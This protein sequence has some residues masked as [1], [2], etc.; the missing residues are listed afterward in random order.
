MA[1]LLRRNDASGRLGHR[2]RVVA[3]PATFFQ[4]RA[5]ARAYRIRGTLDFL[6]GRGEIAQRA[7]DGGITLMECRIWTI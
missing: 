1:Y 3:A 4:L 5:F 6:R 2:T 7:P